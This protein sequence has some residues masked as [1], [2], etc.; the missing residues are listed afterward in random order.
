MEDTRMKSE[1]VIATRPH[2]TVY[3]DGDTVIK[4]FDEKFSKSDILNEALNQSRVE[5]TGLAIP[6][7]LEVTK[8]DGKWAIISEYIEGQTLEQLM[9]AHPDKADEY[10]EL[11]ISLQTE[12]LSKKAPLLNDLLEK[13]SRK[14]DQADIDNGTK[15]DLHTLLSGVHKHEKVCHGDF[16][17]SNIVITPEGNAY[18]LD[19]AHATQGN[20]S[21]DAATTY[22]L[23]HLDGKAE[24][25]EKYIS[26]FCAKTGIDKKYI[27]RWI[28]IVA[29]A[30]TLKAEPAQRALLEKWINVFD[31]E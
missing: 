27:Q 10:M 30:Q 6:K 28:P 5:E 8:I 13:M 26:A 3:R 22:L 1:Q 23:F 20:A 2:K 17:P 16:N 19:W 12:I 4:L 15:Y 9:E 31:Y 7:V 21:A 18:I 29:A 11:F 14:I 24:L 25:A